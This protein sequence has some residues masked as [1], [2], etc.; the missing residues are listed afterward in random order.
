ML[1]GIFVESLWIDYVRA[2][3]V[4]TLAGDVLIEK[5]ITEKNSLRKKLESGYNMLYHGHFNFIVLLY[6]KINSM[7]YKM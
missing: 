2:A 3:L 6:N 5:T 1:I 4:Y 7:P